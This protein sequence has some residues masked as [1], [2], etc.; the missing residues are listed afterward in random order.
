MTPPHI[1]PS[2]IA[3]V[4]ADVWRRNLPVVEAVQHA[5]QRFP[6]AMQVKPEKEPRT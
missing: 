3:A 4:R 5:I 1:H 2:D 6:A